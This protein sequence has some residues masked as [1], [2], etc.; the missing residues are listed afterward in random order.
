MGRGV[1]MDTK[2][3]LLQKK[4]ELENIIKAKQQQMMI[5]LAEFT[6]ELSLY[7]EHP[8]DIGSEVFEREKDFGILELYELE[9]EKVNNA[10]ERLE[11]GKYGLCEMCGNPIEPARLQRLSHTTLCAGCARQTQD[12]FIRPTEQDVITA[13]AMADLGETFQISGHDFYDH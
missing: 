12:E 11:A 7:D 4:Q 10:L 9:L 6:D 13:G 5:P 3:R 8:A 2:T 1:C